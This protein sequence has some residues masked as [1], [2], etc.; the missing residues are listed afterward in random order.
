MVS[1]SNHVKTPAQDSPPHLT[2]NSIFGIPKLELFEELSAV[3]KPVYEDELPETLHIVPYRSDLIPGSFAFR[4]VNQMA[5]KARIIKALE[6]GY[7]HLRHNKLKVSAELTCTIL[8]IPRIHEV[9]AQLED[10]FDNFRVVHDFKDIKGVAPNLDVLASIGKKLTLLREE[11]GDYLVEQGMAIPRPPRWG[12]N[13]DPE[14][15]WN[16]NDFEIFC[17]SYQHEVKGFL[18]TISPYFPRK[19]K[20]D[21]DFPEP[22]TPTRVIGWNISVSELPAPGQIKVPRFGGE[23]RDIPPI[24]TITSQGRLGALLKDNTTKNPLTK[25]NTEQPN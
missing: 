25:A 21:D 18:K 10:F 20:S 8:R 24:S 2:G 4:H 12:K 13:N 7:N 17:V 15:W 5:A 22:C 3:S 9:I 14:Q 19:P 23:D 6:L 11:A 16:I 1:P